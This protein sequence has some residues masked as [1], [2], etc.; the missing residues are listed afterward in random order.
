MIGNRGPSQQPL[1][2]KGLTVKLLDFVGH[3]VSAAPCHQ[4]SHFSP[5]SSNECDD[6][7]FKLYFQKEVEAKLANGPWSAGPCFKQLSLI[8]I[9]TKSIFTPFLFLPSLL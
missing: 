6:V 4:L 1:S 8:D 2:L 3:R 9:Q 7:A 5:E